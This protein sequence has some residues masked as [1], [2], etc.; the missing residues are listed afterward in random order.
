MKTSFSIDDIK[1]AADT[2]KYS[3]LVFICLS[4]CIL[5]T[6]YAPQSKS[7]VSQALVI[8]SK[9]VIPSLFPFMFLSGFMTQSG[10]FNIKVRIFEKMSNFLFGLPQ[11]ALGVFFISALGGYPVGGKMTKQLYENGYLTQNQAQ[12]L[13]L[14]CVNPGPAFAVSIVGLSL[15]GNVKLGYILY[16]SVLISNIIIAFLT[17]FIADSEIAVT[18]PN[19]KT[20]LYSAF[21]RSGSAAATSI[22]SVCTFIII[23]SCFENILSSLINNDT[24]TDVLSGTLEVTTG[25][26]RLARFS[27]VPLLSG[28]TAWGG[29]SVH[30]QI[31]DCIK[32]T[33]LDLKLFLTSRILCAG[34]SSVISDLLLKAFPTEVSVFAPKSIVSSAAS[35]TSFPISVAML[36]TCCVFLIGDYSFNSRRKY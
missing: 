25:C 4:F 3:V 5:L 28:V 13:L 6:V 1:K 23:F 36:L 20:D 19:E 10:I 24:V 12:R 35:E 26:E 14:F 18:V 15:L 29:I 2:L 11:C 22:V 32:K 8:C 9:T 7:G 17:R 16:F 21:V 34:L 30:C 27:S 33:G 31:S